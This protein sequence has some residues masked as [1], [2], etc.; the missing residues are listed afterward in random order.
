MTISNI[1]F[2]SLKSFRILSMFFFIRT[3]KFVIVSTSDLI[4]HVIKFTIH[5]TTH[6]LLYLSFYLCLFILLFNHVFT[7]AFFHAIEFALHFMIICFYEFHV[8]SMLPSILARSARNISGPVLGLD[9]AAHPL[10]TL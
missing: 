2:L 1:T 6:L 4:M 3:I 5:V 8:L 9:F 7:Y 10:V